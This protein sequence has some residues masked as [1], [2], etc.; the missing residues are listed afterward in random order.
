VPTSVESPAFEATRGLRRALD[1]VSIYR[2]WQAPFQTRKFEPI[3]RHNDLTAITR[4]LDVGCGPAINTDSFPQGADY[5]GLDINPR[6][7]AHARRR[8]GRRFLATDVTTWRPD[9]DVHF[10]FVLVNS[11]FHHV[12]DAA[13]RRILRHLATVMG[14]GGYVHVVDLVLP[15]RSGLARTL[16]LWDRGEYPRP[17]E[18]WRELLTESFETVVF[19]PFPIRFAGRSLWDLVYFKGRPKA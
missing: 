7:V 12:D 11:F 17:L 18:R 4:V 15:A 2:L 6:Y 5:L 14:P 13:T 16:A 3:R 8:T 10:D 1:L 9:P 19:E